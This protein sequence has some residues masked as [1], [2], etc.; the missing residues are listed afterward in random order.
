MDPNILEAEIMIT[1]NKS[2]SQMI[3]EALQIII[4]ENDIYEFYEKM[5]HFSRFYGFECYM[6]H[7]KI[8]RVI[9]EHFN[10]E[11]LIFTEGSLNINCE[12]FNINVL[13]NK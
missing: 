3:N 12:G 10:K 2:L 9:I 8:N 13:I 7:E 4:T 5:E 1:G 6:T 11:V